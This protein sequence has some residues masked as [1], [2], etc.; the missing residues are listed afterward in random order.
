M[1]KISEGN[2]HSQKLFERNSLK[3]PRNKSGRKK[4]GK[5][6]LYLMLKVTRVSYFYPYF[7]SNCFYVNGFIFLWISSN[8][9]C[10]TT[11]LP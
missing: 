1:L 3:I 10:E 7:L 2:F 5:T 6:E 8:F 4:E 11:A 9:N